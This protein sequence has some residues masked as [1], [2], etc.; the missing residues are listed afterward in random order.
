MLK[1]KTD[2]L[3]IRCVRG[4]GA[5]I[6]TV[7]TPKGLDFL[8]RS[9]WGIACAT[10]GVCLLWY[11]IDCLVEARTNTTGGYVPLYEGQGYDREWVDDRWAGPAQYRREKYADACV[12]ILFV[13][14]CAGAAY[15]FFVPRDPCKEPKLYFMR[16]D[17][18]GS[19]PT[20]ALGVGSWCGSY[21]D[22]GWKLIDR[23]KA[24]ALAKGPSGRYVFTAGGPD[25]FCSQ[26]D[27]L[28]IVR[29]QRRVGDIAVTVEAQCMVWAGAG[30]RGPNYEALSGGSRL[31]EDS[32]LNP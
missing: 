14:L 16:C 6:L 13:G 30:D 4:T 22:A 12:A 18:N 9:A 31:P 1:P 20:G 25:R 27:Y 7:T 23:K 17:A 5:V 10:L 8:K 24:R 21:L 32:I 19:E 26:R 28:S 11:A 29:N 15:H 2:D 3:F